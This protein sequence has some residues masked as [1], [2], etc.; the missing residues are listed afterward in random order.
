MTESPDFIFSVKYINSKWLSDLVICPDS[1]ALWQKQA[2]ESEKLSEAHLNT[3]NILARAVTF[4]QIA[5]AISAIAI[6]TKRKP[7]WIFSILLMAIGI[8]FLVQAALFK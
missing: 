8:F 4:F 5:I 7:L 6:L 3:H 2:E 1:C